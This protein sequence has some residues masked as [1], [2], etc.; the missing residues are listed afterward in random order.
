MI[1][2]VSFHP[3]TNPMMKPVRT[4]AAFWRNMPIF[5]P[6]PSCTLFKSLYKRKKIIK[7]IF[8]AKDD[9]SNYCLPL[10][11]V[12]Y[13]KVE[14]R[15]IT[16]W[17]EIFQT[18]TKFTHKPWRRQTGDLIIKRWL[19]LQWKRL[20]RKHEASMC[21]RNKILIVLSCHFF[22]QITDVVYNYA[23]LDKN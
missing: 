5:W 2:R 3:Y 18:K 9:Q 13:H 19:T 22:K 17:C 21:I 23:T 12:K 15:K 1:T 8:K 10:S 16:N 4:I 14:P 6:M 11:E 20:Q 7:Y